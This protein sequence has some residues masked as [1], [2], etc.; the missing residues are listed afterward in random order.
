[1]AEVLRLARNA[2][3]TTASLVAH[4]AELDTRRL[5]LGAGFSSLFTYCTAV[6]GL[7]ESETY[8]RI[9]AARAAR[10][11]ALVLDRLADGSLNLT[12]LRLIAR[13]LTAANH[14]ELVAAAA[15]R[16]KHEV[17]LLVAR[18]FPRADVASS[19]RKLP[20]VPRTAARPV[21]SVPAVAAAVPSGAATSA[22][23]ASASASPASGAPIVLTPPAPRRPL[24]SPLAAD[25]YE[26]RFTAGADTYDKL[27]RAQDL[28]RHAIPSGDPAEIFDRALTALLEDLARKKCA[29][30][31]R[32]RASRGT[33]RGS[34]HIP[35]KVKRA[36]WLRD[37]S[38][39][40][41]VA[42]G[43]RRCAERGFLELHHVEP[44]AVG[45]EATVDNIQLRCRAH[46]AYEAELFYGPGKVVRGDGV[47]REPSSFYSCVTEPR[48]RSG[49]SSDLWD[50]AG[51]FATRFLPDEVGVCQAA[52]QEA[53][54]SKEVV[55]SMSWRRECQ[56][57]QYVSRERAMARSTLSGATAP[58]TVKRRSTRTMRCGSSG[59]RSARRRACRA[60][61]G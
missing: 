51:S 2:R 26:I 59:A 53:A 35:A 15:G 57:E 7:S 40:A 44:H 49:T 21:G 28:L 48:T 25:R 43:G 29:A 34:R 60:R 31:G 13:H 58:V 3:A 47:V 45:G 46:N 54:I 55:N 20:A 33:S 6:L 19:V 16:T 4:L 23:P 10:R 27:R 32:P 50:S 56:T 22:A 11:F 39:C 18:R 37:G 24:V 36:V 9:E 42:R 38:R 41:F 17:E 30:T 8:N 12:T 61:S 5:Y 1:M 14:E 52:D